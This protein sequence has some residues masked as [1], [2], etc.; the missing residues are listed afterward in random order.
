MNART[1]WVRA[2]QTRLPTGDA[3]S[4]TAEL[5][6]VTPLLVMFLLLV[7]L[8]GRLV[9]ARIDLDA[10]ASAAARA[11]SLARTETAARSQAESV[12]METLSAR[13]LTCHDAEITVSGGF[14]PG[15]AVTVEV[16]CRVYLEDLVLLDVPGS[17][18]VSATATSPID[19]WRGAGS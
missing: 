7:V 15:G 1:R 13:G 11:A 10:A 18:T 9:S 5:T 17:Q 3:G 4:S 8:C 19:Q 16:S 12:A 6:L 2:P 14:T